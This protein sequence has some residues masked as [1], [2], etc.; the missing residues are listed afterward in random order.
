MFRKLS[1]VSLKLWAL[2]RLLRPKQ[3][4]KNTFVF[5]GVLF[6]ARLHNVQ[7]MTAAGLTSVAFSLLGSSVYVLNDYP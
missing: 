3:W 7:F 6:G 4:V 5:A 1:R 2:V